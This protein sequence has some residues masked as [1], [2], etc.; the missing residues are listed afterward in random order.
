[1]PT[2][3]AQKIAKFMVKTTPKHHR[4]LM[5]KVLCALLSFDAEACLIDMPPFP[6]TSLEAG[7]TSDDT[8]ILE[9]PATR[10]KSPFYRIR[11]TN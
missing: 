9:P 5:I 6:K 11:Q 10:S 3:S 1:M 8:H 2:G 7:G 4:K